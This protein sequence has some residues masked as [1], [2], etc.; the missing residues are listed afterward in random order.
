MFFLEVGQPLPKGSRRNTRG[1]WHFLVEMCHWRLA[2]KES[3][4]VGSEDNQELIDDVFKRVDLGSIE[5]MTAPAPFHDLCLQF[6]SNITLRTFTTSAAA[7]DGWIQWRL[8]CPDDNVWIVDGGGHLVN[9]N[10][11]EI[12]VF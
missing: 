7:T 10:A 2:T 6:S 1:E 5:K 11:H 3:M 8:F 12:P 9:M 4:L